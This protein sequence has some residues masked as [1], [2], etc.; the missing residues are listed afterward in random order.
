MGKS[1]KLKQRQAAAEEADFQARFAQASR[2]SKARANK[3]PPPLLDE[4]RAYD[5]HFVRSPADFVLRTRSDHRDKQ[6]LELARHLF[7]RFRVPR[8]LDQVWSAYLPERA[9][10]R[11]IAQRPR[12]QH[13][14]PPEPVARAR[15][16]NLAR[17]DFRAWFICVAQGGSLYKS[18]TKG[19]LTKKET[20]AFLAAPADLDLCQAVI[21]AVALC[22]GA[23]VGA[24]LRLARSRLPQQ[25]LTEFWLDAVRFFCLP[26]NEP[27]SPQQVNDLI[28]YLAARQAEDRAFRLLGGGH[29][30]PAL[31]RRMESWHRALARARDLSGIS[32]AGM[33]L[34]DHEIK[35]KDPVRHDLHILWRFRQITTGKDLAAEGTA[36]RHCVF[37]YKHGCVNGSCSIWSLTRTDITGTA[38]RRLTIELRADGTIAQKRGLANRRPRPDEEHVVAQ[39]AQAM[40][41]HN[42]SGW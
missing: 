32:W 34:P 13:N 41:L 10:P 14:P 23:S 17:I 33:D 5:R 24:G 39:W 12:W 35:Q 7:V 3:P 30:L 8:I 20:H 19:L 36:M 37:S 16:P 28:D 4:L 21:H 6:V 25:L 38:A 42:R 40:G 31:L 1:V 26:G 18:H 11:P 15:N 29:T 22:A 2:Q 27:S 9:A